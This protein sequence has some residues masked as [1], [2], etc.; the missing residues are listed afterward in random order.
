MSQSPTPLPAFLALADGRIFHGLSLGATGH[1]VGEVC[2]NTSLTGYQE[3]LTDPSY[4]D[5]IIT[6]TYPHIGNV[7]VNAVDME[8]DKIAVRGLIVRAPAR[9]TSNYRAEQSLTAWLT[10][11]HVV[12][13][14]DIDTR[15]LVR[16]LR[17]GGAQ[18]GVIVADNMSESAAVALANSWEGLE[19]KDLVGQVSC[20]DKHTWQQG[21]YQLDSASFAKPKME[22]HVVALDF[23]CKNNIFRKLSDRGLKVSVV[24]ANTSAADIMAMNPDGIFL[25]NGPGDPAAVVYAVDTIRE[26][27]KG[28]TPI[29]GICMGHQLLS[30]ALGLK[31]FKLKFGHRGGNHPVQDLNTGKI[32]IT[33]QNHGFAVADEHIPEHVE[34]THRSLFDQT[35]EGIKVKNKP[36]FSVQYHPEA[37]PGPQD[38]DYLFDRF[39]DLLSKA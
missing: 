35:V 1:T 12:G 25:S 37:S 29:F 26:L 32:E 13:I 21:S 15:A 34:V 4:T 2:F 18:H 22:K 14:A 10:T 9:Q 33:S 17:D 11:N 7:G 19:N 38:A 36:I 31:T 24:P 30:Q 27:I 16:H 20:K 28:D 39:A 5:Q 8:S 6:F 23:G 3:I